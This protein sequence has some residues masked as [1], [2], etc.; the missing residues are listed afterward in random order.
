[1]PVRGKYQVLS[2][3]ISLYAKN[4]V[5]DVV[6]VPISDDVDSSL[7]RGM[8]VKLKCDDKT[9]SVSSDNIYC[10]GKI[11]FAPGSDDC[12]FMENVLPE[13]DKPVDIPTD[14]DYEHHVC[15]SPVNRYRS[16]QTM[17]IIK[18]ARYK[19][20]MLGKPNK[21]AI[22]KFN[23]NERDTKAIHD[24]IRRHDKIRRS[25]GD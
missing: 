16:I 6:M 8:T 2:Y 18:V 4:K 13:L 23:N 10:Y 14:Y 1:M 24:V 19:Y 3:R 21:I 22:F 7:D 15:R 5:M 20:A 25:Q 17:D 11:D 9:F 12:L